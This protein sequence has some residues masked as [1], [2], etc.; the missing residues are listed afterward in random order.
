MSYNRPLR[1]YCSVP[2]STAVAIMATVGESTP[3]ADVR[4]VLAVG[5]ALV[6]GAAMLL[7]AVVCRANTWEDTIAV[8][9]GVAPEGSVGGVG[10][11][12]GSNDTENDSGDLHFEV[13][14]QDCERIEVRLLKEMCEAVSTWGGY[15]GE[16]L[17]IQSESLMRRVVNSEGRVRWLELV[18]SELAFYT[19]QIHCLR[20]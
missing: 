5:A 2:T 7:A 4:P 16:G 15:E 19:V 17:C 14:V 18:R 8:A 13:A 9:H 11:R 1:V 12:R 6:A 20:K 3:A 10:G